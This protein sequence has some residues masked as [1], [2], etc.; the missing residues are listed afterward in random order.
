MIWYFISGAVIF[1]VGSLFGAAF[2]IAGK[3]SND[4]NDR[5]KS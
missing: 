2:A 3:N 4:R 1:A 5:I